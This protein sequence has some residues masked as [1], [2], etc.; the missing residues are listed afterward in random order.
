MEHQIAEQ[1][2]LLIV[3]DRAADAELSARLIAG[4]GYRCT[5]HRV[6]TEAEFR[7]ELRE[8]QPDLI[9]SDFTL[10][11]YNGMEALELAAQEAPETPFIFVSG[12][13]GAQRAA[14]A[15]TRGANDYVAKHDMSRLVPAV[16]RALEGRSS[17]AVVDRRRLH[18]STAAPNFELDAIERTQRLSAALPILGQLR[19]ATRE[20]RG[21]KELM[22][23][24]CRIVFDSR[25]WAYVFGLLMDAKSRTA[26]PVCWLGAGAEHG[27]EARFHLERSEPEDSSFTGR[28]LRIG[29]PLVY[30]DVTAYS[31]V[32]S[33][34]ERAVAM[35]GGTVVSLPL[36]VSGSI[37]GGLTMGTAK[38]ACV[39]EQEL[40]LLEMFAGQLAAGVCA[41]R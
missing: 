8:F 37:V 4:G 11:R 41:G 17:R 5:W 28:A 35:P 36:V 15:L 2:R 14:E 29:S 26:L 34:H 23:A 20:A 21:R 27:G 39:S 40:V 25:Q 6:E 24:A 22:Q 1:V 33:A 10:P 13:I 19:A 31:G 3:D 32:M 12:S 9:L 18:P 30:M 38:R 16:A 7:A